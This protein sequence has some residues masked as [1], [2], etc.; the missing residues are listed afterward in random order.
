[1]PIK[2]IFYVSGASKW[3]A[4]LS[5]QTPPGQNSTVGDSPGL[6]MSDNK[7]TE[8]EET[9]SADE[10]EVFKCHVCNGD[11]EKPEFNTHFLACLEKNRYT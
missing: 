11:F 9:D 4:G 5:T 6:T 3:G 10:N 8:D 7:I 2:F 1:M